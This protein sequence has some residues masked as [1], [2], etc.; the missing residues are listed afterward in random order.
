MA[1][2]SVTRQFNFET[3]DGSVFSVCER[4][5]GHEIVLTIIGDGGRQTCRLNAQQWEALC[6]LRYERL[7]CPPLPE[8]QDVAA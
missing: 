5:D 6:E 3:V 7:L 8:V 1:T 4:V 2:K